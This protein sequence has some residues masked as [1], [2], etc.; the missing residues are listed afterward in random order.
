[1]SI[2]ETVLKKLNHNGASRR[3]SKSDAQLFLKTFE[4]LIQHLVEKRFNK[5]KKTTNNE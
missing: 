4:L 1:M 5:N 2:V 3:Y